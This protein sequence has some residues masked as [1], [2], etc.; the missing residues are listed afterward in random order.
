MFKD[1]F[2]VFRIADSRRKWGCNWV[3][4][5]D[6]FAKALVEATVLLSVGATVGFGLTGAWWFRLALGAAT[7]VARR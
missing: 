7:T 5:E 1:V 3:A 2:T 4:F 6:R